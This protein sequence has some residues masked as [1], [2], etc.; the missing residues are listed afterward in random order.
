MLYS[1]KRLANTATAFCIV[2]I[3]LLLL[4][5]SDEQKEIENVINAYCVKKSDT[6][7]YFKTYTIYKC[8]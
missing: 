1:C 3:V 7:I 2:I 5:L 8:L 6:S 4:L